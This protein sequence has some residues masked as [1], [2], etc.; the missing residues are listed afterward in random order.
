MPTLNSEE[1]K[2]LTESGKAGMPTWSPDG[3]WIAYTEGE[4]K[5]TGIWVMTLDADS[6]MR[7]FNSTTDVTGKILKTGCPISSPRP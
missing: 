7:A 3:E 2:K 1:P 4:D 6:G 5:G